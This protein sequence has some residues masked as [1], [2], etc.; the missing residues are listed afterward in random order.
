MLSLGS[1]LLG[2]AELAVLAA[3]LGFS[4]Y[5]LRG[6][7]LAAWEGAPARPVEIVAAVALL[8][9]ISDLVGAVGL[10]PAGGVLAASV[11]TAV[12]MVLGPAGP[13]AASPPEGAAQAA[14][15]ARPRGP[16]AGRAGAPRRRP[17]PARP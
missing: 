11:L 1:Y 9:G 13:V 14:A 8:L 15:L 5:R 10:S 2:A 16:G 3:S 6:R 12:A 7:F 17:A 4:A